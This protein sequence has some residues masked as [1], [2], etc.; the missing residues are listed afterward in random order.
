MTDKKLYE[1]NDNQLNDIAG[2]A[3][4][5]TRL[6]NL[7]ALEASSIFEPLKAELAKLKA[8]GYDPNYERDKLDIISALSHFNFQSSYSVTT[9]LLNL[10][11]EKYWSLV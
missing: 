3:D 10:F 1:L 7:E 4:S 11:L 9:R 6:R 8:L 5:K 2:G